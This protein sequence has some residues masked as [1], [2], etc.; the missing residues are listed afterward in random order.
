VLRAADL[1]FEVAGGAGLFRDAGF[2]RLFRDLQSSRF[3]PLQDGDQRHLAA[4][5]AFGLD[6]DAG[7]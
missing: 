3:H 6:P 2:E 4:A 1:A 5:L 7:Q